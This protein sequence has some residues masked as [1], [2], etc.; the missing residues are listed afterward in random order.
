MKKYLIRY[1]YIPS[2]GVPM[3][4]TDYAIVGAISVEKAKQTFIA[5]FPNYKILNI[6]LE[7]KSNV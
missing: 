4:K 7:V 6:Y 1:S 3:I 2:D 5:S